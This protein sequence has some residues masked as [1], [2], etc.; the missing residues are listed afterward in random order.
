ML[1]ALLLLAAGLPSALT[2][3]E[4]PTQM[5]PASFS[6]L[7]KKA[8]TTVVNIRTEKIIKGGGRVFRHFFGPFGERNPF[9]DFFG[10]FMDNQPNRDFRQ[11]SLGSGFILDSE[12]YIVTN[13]HVI[14]DADKIRVRLFNDEELDAEVVGR[15]PKTDLALI[16]ID[17]DET[18]TPLVMG[19]SDLLEIGS[20]VVAIGSPFGLEQTVTAGIVSAK[21]RIIGSGPYDDFIQTDA[22]INPGNSGGP[23]I[24]LKGEVVGI[25]T[26]I[27]ASGQGIGFAIPINMAKK[28]INQLKE[29]GEVTRGWLGVAIQNLTDELKSYYQMGDRD[30]VLV[31]QVFQDDPADRAGIKAK[32]VIVAIDDQPVS[33]SR[34]LSRII[35]DSPVGGKVKIT[36]IREGKEQSISVTLAKRDDSEERLASDPDSTEAL[37]FKVS[38]LTAE[39]AQ[40]LGLDQSETGVVVS[41]LDPS[42]K[43]AGAGLQQGDLIKEVNHAGIESVEDFERETKKGKADGTLQ[44]LIMRPRV[45]FLVINIT[46]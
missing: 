36:F 1:L 11:R 40:R 12:G 35:A 16:K 37:G 4:T 7:A 9:E 45:G 20:W 14:E 46:G 5:V 43:G 34:E 27:V 26:A 22:S 29:G 33:T 39:M 30:G 10:P 19:D 21:G 32:D 6:E 18:L 31:T 42:G 28:I 24:N 38:E 2:A 17:T 13:N 3:K 44:L 23:L 41:W 8:K 15:D 25:N